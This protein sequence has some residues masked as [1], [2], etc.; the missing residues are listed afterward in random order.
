MTIPYNSAMHVFISDAHVRTDKSHRCRMLVKFLEEIRPR[1]TDLYI[2][3]DLFEIWF[4]YNLVVPKDY[5]GL[6]VALQN[7][8]HEGKSIHYL[9]GNHEIAVGNFLGDF[10]FTVHRGPTIFRING[11]RVLLAHGH[12]IDK[13]SWTT[14]WD[15]LLTSRINHALYRLIHPDIGITLA[16]RIAFLSRKQR[17]SIGLAKMLENYAQRQLSDV[18]VVILAHSHI[19]VYNEYP[20][21]KYYINAGD[22]VKNFSYVVIDGSTISL[23]YYGQRNSAAY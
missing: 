15:N 22:W 9:L 19:P 21:N 5:F 1:L 2:L 3:G 18:D 11:R 14:I 10:G 6:L 23:D 20:G 17:P 13:R 12:R 16:Q 8:L 7:I 4:E